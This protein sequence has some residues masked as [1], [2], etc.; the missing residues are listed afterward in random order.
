MTFKD[1]MKNLKKYRKEMGESIDDTEVVFK[2][3]D[4]N[5]LYSADKAEVRLNPMLNLTMIKVE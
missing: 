2:Y 5:T 4:S 1:F 3:S